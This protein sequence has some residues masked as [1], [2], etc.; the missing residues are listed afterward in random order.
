MF[1]YLWHTYLT[2]TAIKRSAIKFMVFVFE[3]AVLMIVW[4]KLYWYCYVRFLV[5][6]GM[7]TSDCASDR[8]EIDSKECENSATLKKLKLI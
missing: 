4:T 6:I 7:F 5:L 1:L 2:S 8:T 3:T